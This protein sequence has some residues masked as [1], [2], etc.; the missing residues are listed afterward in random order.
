MN[1]KQ[2]KQVLANMKMVEAFANGETVQI[3]DEGAWVDIV[4]FSTFTA[5]PEFYRIKPKPLEVDVIVTATGI[6]VATAKKDGKTLP[7]WDSTFP[8]DAPHRIVH[9]TEAS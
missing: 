9:L 5:R 4:E 6:L 3:Y 8:L 7:W 2:A 1:R